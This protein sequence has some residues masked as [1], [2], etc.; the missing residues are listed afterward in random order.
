MYPASHESAAFGSKAMMGSDGVD[1]L[2][3]T[4]Q[5]SNLTRTTFDGGCGTSPSESGLAAL[6]TP[7]RLVGTFRSKAVPDHLDGSLRRPHSG[8]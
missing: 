8:A 7:G 4:R 3:M 6:D 1:G 2:N 5:P